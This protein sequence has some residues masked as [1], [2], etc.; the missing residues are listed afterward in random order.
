MSSASRSM[1]S[2]SS[3]AIAAKSR[4]S[5]PRGSVQLAP[6]HSGRSIGEMRTSMPS[7]YVPPCAG[8][9]CRSAMCAWNIAASGGSSSIE[10]AATC[11]V[12][13]HPSPDGSSPSGGD[14]PSVVSGRT[15]VPV[16]ML[17]TRKSGTRSGGS[18]ASASITAAST[19]LL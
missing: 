16:P 9:F 15:V 2:S 5:S 13:H 8:S 19:G 4:S 17:S 14:A 10:V 6:S 12:R 11:S 7:E 1:P 18:L 3:S